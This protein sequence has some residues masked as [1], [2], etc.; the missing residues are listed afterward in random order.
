MKIIKYPNKVLTTPT[1]D[2][3]VLDPGDIDLTG[4]VMM[5]HKVL[6]QTPTGLALA[7]NQVGLPLRLF[8]L[9]EDL[10]DSCSVPTAII[11][12]RIVIGAEREEM[13]EGCLSFPGI[14]LKI[15]RAKRITC[16]FTQLDGEERIIELSGLSAR[17]FQHECEHLDGNLFTNNV[18]R[19]QRYQVFGRMKKGR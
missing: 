9:R 2:V 7:A 5:M 15:T 19:I 4:L 11:N 1:K 8:V 16:T 14:Y 3:D 17:V 18:D 13:E 6:S 12:P 10:A